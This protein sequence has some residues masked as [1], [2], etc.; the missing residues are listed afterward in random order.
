VGTG[1]ARATIS[2][3]T[4][5]THI[6]Y[7]GSAFKSSKINNGTRFFMGF[8][9]TEVVNATETISQVDNVKLLTSQALDTN[10][11]FE[12][13]PQ[14]EPDFGNMIGYGKTKYVVPSG[15][16]TKSDTDPI[17]N[18]Q[19]ATNPTLIVNVDNLPHKSYIGKGFKADAVLG[20]KPVGST[21]GLTKMIA[22]VPRH[23]DDSSGSK[24]N[25]GPFYFDY[26]PY[27]IP[28]RNATEI[29]LNELDITIRN[30]DGTLAT[31]II[32][33]HMLLNISGVEGAGEGAF[34]GSIG[35]P[36]EAPRSY[37]TL[38]MTNGQLTPTL[39]GGFA[40]P[41]KPLN[42]QPSRHD[43]A[44]KHNDLEPMSHL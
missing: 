44:D 22:K 42:D 25:T 24:A 8:G 13:Y 3:L 35:K 5:Y 18:Q 11:Y 10:D 19:I 23:H 38:N 33:T 28:L 20:S 40:Q 39:R 6:N 4:D 30:P 34:G 37:D 32:E 15:S 21:Q 31:D 17:P 7:M 9:N 12:F 26:F 14:Y 27:S 16:S 41:T 29:T 43:R 36:I 1:E 2:A